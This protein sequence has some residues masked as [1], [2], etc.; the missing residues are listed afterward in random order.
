MNRKER[1][2]NRFD[3]T[4]TKGEIQTFEVDCSD[5]GY[6]DLTEDGDITVRLDTPSGM[7]TLNKS[8][9]KLTVNER[10]VSVEIDA[11]L[12][13]VHKLRVFVTTDDGRIALPKEN[14]LSIWVEP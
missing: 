3:E 13:G 10:T 12:P 2:Q 5:A 1:R 4:L 9:E 8:D 7:T 6:V 14:P 11:E